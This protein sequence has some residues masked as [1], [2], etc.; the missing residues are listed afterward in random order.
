MELNEENE[1]IEKAIV[2]LAIVLST[3]FIVACGPKWFEW[4]DGR[5]KGKVHA[6][7]LS[8]NQKGSSEY[9]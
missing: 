3:Y 1:H 4:N 7:Q 2:L 8:V 9:T 5:M 6:P